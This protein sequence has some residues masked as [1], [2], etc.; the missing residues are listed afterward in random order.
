MHEAASAVEHAAR[1]ISP[2]HCKVDDFNFFEM[3]R[4]GR[5]WPWSDGN[6]ENQI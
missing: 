5:I 3:L 6:E 2:F 1:S 4:N